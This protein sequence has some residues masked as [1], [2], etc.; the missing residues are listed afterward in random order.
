MQFG[1]RSTARENL[2][3]FFGPKKSR[4]R[5]SMEGALPNAVDLPGLDREQFRKFAIRDLRRSVFVTIP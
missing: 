5:R 1:E 3:R 4:S 2:G